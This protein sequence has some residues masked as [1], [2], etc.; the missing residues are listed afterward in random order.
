MQSSVTSCNAK[1]LSNCSI[2]V[3][4]PHIDFGSQ[5]LLQSSAALVYPTVLDTVLLRCRMVHSPFFLEKN[6][7]FEHFL[8]LFFNSKNFETDTD[9]PRP[10]TS[11]A[12][13]H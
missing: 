3:P 13:L 5:I 2:P 6:K 8:N 1:D 4:Q 11:L 12:W 7:S 10:F 9:I